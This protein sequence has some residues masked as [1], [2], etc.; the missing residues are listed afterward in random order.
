[1]TFF[2]PQCWQ[3]IPAGAEICPHCRARLSEEDAKPFVVKLR[4]ALHH[5]EPETA[6]RAAWILG[7]RQEASAVRDL[8]HVVETSQDSFLVEAAS[9]A[10]GKIGDP[11]AIPALEQAVR[12][13]PVRVRAASRLAI[14][15]IRGRLR[16]VSK[17]GY[18]ENPSG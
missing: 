8:I 1:M 13:G 3:E 6:I 5:P 12:T 4:S 2:C 9:E 10:L 14:E 16:P 15:N 11:S 18:K 17:E 7:E